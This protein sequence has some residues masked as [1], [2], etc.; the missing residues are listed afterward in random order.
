[1]L[2][3]AA[4]FLPGFTTIEQLVFLNPNG[5]AMAMLAVLAIAIPGLERPAGPGRTAALGLALALALHVH[6]TSLP[7]FLLVPA[8]LGICSKDGAPM[9]RVAL[10]MAAGFALPF[11]PYLVSQAAMGF[12]DWTSAGGYVAKQVFMA[13]VVNAPQVIAAYLLEGPRVM[14]TYLL[15]WSDG[16]AKWL[17]WASA[18]L[19]FL[20]LAAAVRGSIA[21]RRLVQFLA[22]LVLTASWIAIA[23]PTTPVQFTWALAVPVGA[24]IALGLW[25]IARLGRFA[26]P[27]VLAMTAGAF[28][29]N[30][31]VVRALVVT[32]NQGEGRLPSL[33]MDIKGGLPPTVYRDVW[34]AAHR[35]DE[36]GRALCAA[37][38]LRNSTDTSPTSWTR[39]WGWTPSSNAAI[40]R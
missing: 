37:G 6:P 20:S 29:L 18:G 23:K 19:A 30:L 32:V 33:I 28:V 35:H 31:L 3:A 38:A 10:A 22:M 40:A 26:P 4:L 25:S 12:P 1:V 14:A 34:F 9:V 15:R 39:T 13:N 16:H 21:R 8:V 17:G 27:L 5:V 7:M 2:W 11:I 24:L 36:L